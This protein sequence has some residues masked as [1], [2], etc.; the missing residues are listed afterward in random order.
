M[1]GLRNKQSLILLL[2]MVDIIHK[3]HG[4]T[5]QELLAYLSDET[6][7]E[8]PAR[9]IGTQV[10]IL[11]KVFRMKIIHD[12]EHG[13]RITDWGMINKERFTEMMRELRHEE[14]AE[15]AKKA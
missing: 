3:L 15:Q 7:A 13:Y 12:F 4:A 11:R 14:R 9:S 2:K 5:T 1:L 8:I 10:N 6:T